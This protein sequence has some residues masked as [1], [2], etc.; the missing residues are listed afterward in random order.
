MYSSVHLRTLLRKDTNKVCSSI[1]TRS[2]LAYIWEV[3]YKG[4]S[5]AITL[6]IYHQSR[7]QGA[8]TSNESLSTMLTLRYYFTPSRIGIKH[9]KESQS[10]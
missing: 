8:S 1:V 7:M 6:M 10:R 9:S 4:L 5:E 3:Y 2:Y